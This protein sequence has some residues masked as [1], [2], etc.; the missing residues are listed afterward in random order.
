MSQGNGSSNEAQPQMGGTTGRFLVLLAE[1]ATEA[2]VRDIQNKPPASRGEF[3]GL[4]SGRGSRAGAS[5]RSERFLQSTGSRARDGAAQ[6]T[7]GTAFDGRRRGPSPIL[8]PS[9][10][11]ASSMQSRRRASKCRLTEALGRGRWF[12]LVPRRAGWFQ[13]NRRIAHCADCGSIRGGV[14][15]RI[16]AGVNGIIDSL[17]AGARTLEAP[18]HDT[19]NRQPP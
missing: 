10:P 18:Q 3:R 2:A 1:D 6:S 8:P 7:E 4:F 15:A 19:G 12:R 5:R 13:T 16:P 11:S 9:S 14:L 17:L